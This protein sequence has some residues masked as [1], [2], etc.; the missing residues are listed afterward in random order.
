MYYILF[1]LK[2]DLYTEFKKRETK[3]KLLVNAV[4][5]VYRQFFL[6]QTSD[7]FAS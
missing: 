4:V 5:C 6:N 1:D 3:K 7:E 2:K